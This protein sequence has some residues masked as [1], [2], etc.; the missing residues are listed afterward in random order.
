MAWTSKKFYNHQYGNQI[1]QFSTW[2]AFEFTDVGYSSVLEYV[3]LSS[4]SV[5]EYTVAGAGGVVS[6]KLHFC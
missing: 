1:A 5:L 4:C 2:P 3:R 6:S